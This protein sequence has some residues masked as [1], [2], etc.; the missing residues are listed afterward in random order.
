ML[1]PSIAAA[2]TQQTDAALAIALEGNRA[3]RCRIVS[4][5]Y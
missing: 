5:R 2:P 3:E 1:S 4:P